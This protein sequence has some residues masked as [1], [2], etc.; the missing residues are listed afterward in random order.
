M[1]ISKRPWRQSRYRVVIV[2]RSEVSPVFLVRDVM[3][4]RRWCDPRCAI[5]IEVS[6]GARLS[7]LGGPE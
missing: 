3:A 7:D 2:R 4:Q 1:H 6:I 5:G